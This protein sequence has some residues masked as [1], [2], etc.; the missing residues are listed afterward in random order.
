VPVPPLVLPC[1]RRDGR[2][3]QKVPHPS[4]GHPLRKYTL[5]ALRAGR[6]SAAPFPLGI[7]PPSSPPRAHQGSSQGP[8][9]SALPCTMH[10]R[11][12]ATVTAS[13]MRRSGSLSR[14]NHQLSSAPIAIEDSRIG[15]TSATDVVVRAYRTRM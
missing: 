9:R 8:Q 2:C 13:R 6:W 10:A 4:V 14:N 12:P 5:L 15:A 1:V 11:P 3:R 7:S